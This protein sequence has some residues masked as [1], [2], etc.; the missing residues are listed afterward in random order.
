MD[1]LVEESLTLPPPGGGS[2]AKRP[3]RAN[4][5][6]FTPHSACYRSASLPLQQRLKSDQICQIHPTSAA[7]MSSTMSS[8]KRLAG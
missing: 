7:K 5:A 2:A 6:F 8:A 4:R 3:G 1:D